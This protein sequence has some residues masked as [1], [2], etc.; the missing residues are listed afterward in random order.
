MGTRSPPTV[1]SKFSK[2]YPLMGGQ[3]KDRQ[4]YSYT[5]GPWKNFYDYSTVQY[6]NVCSFILLA[7]SEPAFPWSFCLGN[8]P[9]LR[10]PTGYRWHW[11]DVCPD[12][13]YPV[14]CR[15]A[16]FPFFLNDAG[17]HWWKPNSRCAEHHD[18][19]SHLG[20]CFWEA[21]DDSAVLYLLVALW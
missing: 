1:S 8:R 2:T 4:K 7:T 17:T 3:E 5:L 18:G 19:G 16:E 10:H 21:T 20:T 6:Q 11:G 13:L 9:P 15:W 12:F 14:G